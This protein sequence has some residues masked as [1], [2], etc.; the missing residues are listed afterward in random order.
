MQQTATSEVLKVISSSPGDLGPVFNAMLE[1]AVRICE[2]K[3]VTLWRFD[4]KLFGREASVGTP[5]EFIEF[6]KQRGPFSPTSGNQLSPDD[7]DKG[8]GTYGRRGG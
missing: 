7:G 6:Q 3:F 8:R 2:A 1:N 4:G 5:P